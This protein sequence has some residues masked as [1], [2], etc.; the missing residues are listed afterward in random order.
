[1]AYCEVADVQ[2]RIKWITFGATSTLTT[3]DIEDL[4]E[5]ADAETDARIGQIYTVPVTNAAD[6]KLVKFASVTLAT[7]AAAKILMAQAG[8]DLPKI[9]QD[10]K[11]E[12]ETRIDKI[13]TREIFLENT[14]TRELAVNGPYSHTAHDP[15]APARTWELGEDQWVLIF[16]VLCS[17]LV[18]GFLWLS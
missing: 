12:A 2:Q 15:D 5:E 9:V 18:S 7:Y 16:A 4:I 14:V 3:G 8:G 11:D 13:Q 6:L 1:M 17:T 10:W